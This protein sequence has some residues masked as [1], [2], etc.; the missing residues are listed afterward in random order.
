[1]CAGEWGLLPDYTHWTWR[2][3]SAKKAGA[4]SLSTEAWGRKLSSPVGVAAGLDKHA[5]IIDP[6]MDLGAAHQ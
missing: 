3:G 5:Q 6:L 4:P 1:M 2:I